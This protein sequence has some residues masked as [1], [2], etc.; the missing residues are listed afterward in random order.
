MLL[1]SVFH[2]DIIKVPLESVE[3]A[4]VI[5]E[6]VDVY[7]R[8]DSSADRNGILRALFAR[9][10]QGTTGVKKGIASCKNSGFKASNRNCWSFS[11]RDSL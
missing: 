3:K 7:V 5:E 2:P 1:S 6:L 8:Y 4:E 10:A 11:K 9:E